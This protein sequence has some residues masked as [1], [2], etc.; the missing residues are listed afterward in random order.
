M[1]SNVV[2]SMYI[3]WSMRGKLCCYV[4]T[5]SHSC[6]Y[7]FSNSALNSKLDWELS[8]LLRAGCFLRMCSNPLSSAFFLEGMFCF[9]YIYIFTNILRDN[10]IRLAHFNIYTLNSQHL[11]NIAIVQSILFNFLCDW[12]RYLF[13]LIIMTMII[14]IKINC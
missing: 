11:K 12:N 5:T 9:K 4:I 7:T 3:Y 14:E 8:C 1:L 2:N 6:C 13:F 10:I